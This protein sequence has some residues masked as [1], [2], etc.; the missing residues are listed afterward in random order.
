MISIS[1]SWSYGICIWSGRD[2]FIKS[3]SVKYIF[4]INIDASKFIYFYVCFSLVRW[5][6]FLWAIWTIFCRIWRILIKLV[7]DSVNRFGIILINFKQ[8]KRGIEI[9]WLNCDEGLFQW[10]FGS[11]VCSVNIYMCVCIYI[12]V[13]IYMCVYIY[14]YMNIYIHIYTYICI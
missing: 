1:C 4:L 5:K 6:A 2:H 10:K 13:C 8:P 12:C 9:E 11:V 3:I 14:T 7:Y